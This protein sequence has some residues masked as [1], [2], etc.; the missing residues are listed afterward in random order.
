MRSLRILQQKLLFLLQVAIHA[1]A[2]YRLDY[3][4]KQTR[5]AIYSYGLHRLYVL[6]NKRLHLL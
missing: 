5:L 1:V 6:I 3:L 2:A 4:R